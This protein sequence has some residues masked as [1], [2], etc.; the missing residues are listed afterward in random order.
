MIVQVLRQIQSVLNLSFWS[1]HYNSTAFESKALVHNGAGILKTAVIEN[2]SNSAAFI[3]I[4]DAIAEPAQGTQPLSTLQLPANSM[5]SIEF[6]R[7]LTTGIYVGLSSN[8]FTWEDAAVNG[9]FNIE[10]KSMRA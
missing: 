2:T 10:F 9:V 6:N 7:K 4:F 3:Q 8:Q 1:D 5:A